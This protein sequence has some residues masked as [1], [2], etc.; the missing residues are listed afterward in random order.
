MCT[1]M[2]GYRTGLD[3]PERVGGGGERQAVHRNYGHVNGITITGDAFW[4]DMEP[5]LISIKA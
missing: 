4:F 2:M 5:A 3:I 1:G